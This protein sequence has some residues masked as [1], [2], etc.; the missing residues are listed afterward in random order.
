MKL[1]LEYV[2]AE[3]KSIKKDLKQSKNKSKEIIQQHNEIFELLR[4][5]NDVPNNYSYG[6]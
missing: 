2:M 1:D 4:S 5:G 3:L 6:D